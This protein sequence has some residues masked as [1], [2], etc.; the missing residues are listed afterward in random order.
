MH[1]EAVGEVDGP[2]EEEDHGWGPFGFCGT[3]GGQDAFEVVA[4]DAWHGVVAGDSGVEE[5][6]GA[7]GL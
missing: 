2:G 5:G 3:D 4:A 1:E 7:V 6:E